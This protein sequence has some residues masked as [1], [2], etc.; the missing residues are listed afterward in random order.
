MFALVVVGFS[1]V[2]Q[3]FWLPVLPFWALVLILIDILVIYGLFAKGDDYAR[4]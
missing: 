1:M 3:F 2:L 4:A